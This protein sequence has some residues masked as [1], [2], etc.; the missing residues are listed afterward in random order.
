MVM[1]QVIYITFVFHKDSVLFA[2]CNEWIV[3]SDWTPNNILLP[4]EGDG[5]SKIILVGV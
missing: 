5:G 3:T 4:C 1:T 2:M